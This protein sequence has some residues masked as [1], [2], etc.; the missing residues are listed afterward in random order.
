VSAPIQLFVVGTGRSG[1]RTIADLLDSFPGCTVEHERKPVLLTEVNEYL[2]R[3]R[4]RADIVELLRDTRSI[5]AIGG[6]R[7]SGEANQRLSFVLGPLA[8]TYS[9][10]R[11]IWLIRDGRP[12]VA[13]M[14]HRGAFHP[15]EHELRSAGTKEWASAKFAAHIV[16]EMTEPEWDALDQFGRCCW[17]WSYTNRVIGRDLPVTGLPWMLIRLEDLARDWSRVESLLGLELPLP[18]RVPHSNRS[19]GKPMSWKNWSRG[20]RAT[21]S[22]FC[23]VLMEEHYPGWR[24]EMPSGIPVELSALVSRSA[25]AAR[26]TLAERT[27]PVRRRLGMTGQRAKAASS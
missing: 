22:R 20:Q 8:E 6:D 1:T 15:N 4:S 14:V 18:E 19:T 5:E 21:F 23:G 2:E 12:A 3:K 17:Y 13:S 26:S 16:G 7:L 11:V 27:R 9:E 10:A 24:E 25:Y